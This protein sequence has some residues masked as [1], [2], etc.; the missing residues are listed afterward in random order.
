MDIQKLLHDHRIPIAP[1]GDSN[2]HE[3]W[4]NVRCP[5]CGD[6]STHLGF[7]IQTGHANCW[8]CGWKPL[9]KIIGK[10]LG[11]SIP[12]AKR[13]LKEYGGTPVRKVPEVKR[14]PRTKAHKLPSDT[15]KMNSRHRRY[16]ENRGFDPDKITAEWGVLGT[17]PIAT[18]DKI[19][20][21]H[22]ILAPIWW[23]GE[24]ISWQ[25][26][27]ITGKAKAKYMACPKERELVEHQTVLYGRQ[28]VWT[29]IG[30][31][32]E[33]ITDVWRLGTKAFATFG[34]DYTRQQLHKIVRQFQRIII[35]F[36]QEPQA[37]AQAKKLRAELEIRGL[38]VIQI[39]LKKDPAEL[40]EK[41]ARSLVKK[42]F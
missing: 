39:D 6:H 42:I 7:N 9:D 25:T 15:G 18:L 28:E 34:I 35:I 37:Q 29:E 38:E 5:E 33:G 12:E 3:G 8:R 10:L 20:Y 36:D 14:K 30:I 17:G 32:V 31:C 4:A 23:N 16:L 11:V 26:R 19:S 24:Q 40:S 21:K 41:Q 1:P 13:L 2:Y 27:D 22:R